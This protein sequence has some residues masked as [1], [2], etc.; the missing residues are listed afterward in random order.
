MS[1]QDPIADMFTRVRNAQQRL[2]PFV[3]CPKTN[4]KATILEVLLREGFI[5]GFETV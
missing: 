2:K 5:N 3:L 4:Y 1:M